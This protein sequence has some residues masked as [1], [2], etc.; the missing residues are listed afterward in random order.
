M[1]YQGYMALA[2]DAGVTIELV[3]AAR[4]KAYTDNLAPSLGLRGCDD[5][6]GLDEALGETYT[7]PEGDNAPWF[8]PTDPATADFYGV[9]PLA[10]DGIDD[11][12][13]TI[14]SA[15]LS[16]D[17]SVVVGSRYTGKD[18]RVSGMAFAKDEAGLYAGMSWLDSALNGTE[19][20]RCF[21]DR[22]NLYSSCPPIEVLP[23]GFETPWLL[24][25]PPDA[26]E[27]G[28]WTTTSGTFTSDALGVE[29]TWDATDPSK[30]ACRSITGLI[31]GEQY[32]LR[33][34]N[35]NYGD[36]YVSI[37]EACVERYTNLFDDPRLTTRT[38]TLQGATVVDTYPSSGAPDGGSYFS[39]RMLTANATSP[40]RMEMA[41]T[42]PQGVPVVAGNTYTISWY[43]RKS[44]AGGPATRGDWT[45]Y[46]S[47]G[48][49]I[50]TVSGT[51]QSV[52][53]TWQRFSQTQTAPVG[54]VYGQPRLAWSGTALISQVLDFGMA[55][56]N[57]GGTAVD[58]FDGNYPNARWEGMPNDSRSILAENV[59]YETLSGW[60]GDHPTSPVV[61]DFIPRTTTVYL[62]IQP[63]DTS[64]AT[65]T[66]DLRVE[67]G[68]VRRVA[69]PGVVA[70]GS[71]N[72]FVPPSDGW[73]HQAPATAEVTWITGDAVEYKMIW[74]VARAPFGSALT[75]TTDHGLE[76]TLY[77]LRAGSRYRLLIEFNEGWAATDSD[78]YATV[79]PFASL[80]DTSG[81]VA[82]Y[83][84]NSGG[85]HYWSI[86]FT[87]D[88]TSSVLGLHPN[89][90][91]SLGS[92]G[93]VFW[94]I[95]QFMVEEILP[96]DSTPPTPG[97]D[98][99]RTMYEVKASQGPILTNVRTSP[100]GVMGQVTFS[101]RAGNPF[102][103][104]L[105]EFAGGLP[106][107]TSVQ[108]PDIP[109]SE[110]GLAQIINFSYNPSLEEIPP[111]PDTWLGGGSNL[112]FNG[113]VASATAR[114][115][116]F[117]YR[118]TADSAGSISV[119]NNYYFPG[120]TSGGPTPS[121]GET[122]TV[123]GY[124]RAIAAGSLGTFTM[125]SFVTMT[126]FDPFSV[127]DTVDVAVLNQWYRLQVTFT[128]PDN[129]ALSGIET[130]FFPPADVAAAVGMEVD[131][132]MI[133]R[134][135]V[136]TAPFAQ[137]TPNVEWSDDPNES[138]LLYTPVAEDISEDP[139]CPAPPA[140]PAPP[141]IDDA[142]VTE[143]SAYDRTV[144]VISENTVPRNLTAYP[145]ITLTAGAEPVRQARIRFWE[146]PDNLT[147][148]Q[149]DPCA[150]DG[151]I[152]V[153]YLAA[154]ATMIIDGVLREA[155]VSAPGFE[156][157]DANHVLYGADGGP[158]DWPELTGGIPYLVTLDLDSSASYS[159][160]VMLIDLVVRD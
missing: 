8:D 52:G 51:G 114:L 55:M 45:W 18:I 79:S 141:Q 40:M 105:P 121:S 50:S 31:P 17:G 142:C 82:T 12:T 69:R 156:T 159:D 4:V 157:R 138:A 118:I 154:G 81:A 74:G 78:P 47:G 149:I 86:E 48:V 126:G 66:L 99:A 146:N 89:S 90:N 102:K 57:T 7:T 68:T 151:E 95:D 43:A 103:Y 14:E 21:G 25:N 70:F 148:D 39:R 36:Y 60:A 125:S 22:L 63:T 108:V 139:D 152:I 87:A 111:I 145:V 44:I 92:Y 5:C 158:V 62:S 13:R 80:S 91:L 71:G 49:V 137:N 134:G 23:P 127:Q 77:G 6:E 97:R 160:T 76:R 129:V 124:V 88:S 101:L 153:S 64:P 11:S 24:V 132:L 120:L 41:G 84:S 35:E 9:Y 61:L 16:G 128:L 115:G 34:R 75:Y 147:I 56:L 130:G 113:R 10:F 155:T 29:L 100:C 27:L 98:Q 30:V 107:G 67:S 117:V 1:T 33:M 122:L 20:G 106:T 143:P 2:D 46:D 123:S 133:Q 109:C 54:A 42:G 135:S 85:T 94:Q 119:V 136:A 58:Y 53:T 116:S 96:T 150:F 32:Q 37:S 73:T 65:P 15:E 28:A 72:P 26:A 112:T 131:A 93:S 144:V 19:E 3:N 59:D 110:D 104:R 140:P 83:V 38:M